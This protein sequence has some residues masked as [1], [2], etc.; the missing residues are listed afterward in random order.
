MIKLAIQNLGKYNE[1]ELNFKWVTLPIDED[2][3][4]EVLEEI[5]INEEYEEYFIADYE[6][7]LGLI[8]GEYSNI[9]ELNELAERLENLYEQ[10][11]KI[12]EAIIELEGDLE[13]ALDIF[14]SGDFTYFTDIY[15]NSD[16]AYAMI[17]EGIIELKD[18]FLS[19]YIDY[20]RL[21]RD[22]AMDY[23]ISGNGIAIN[24]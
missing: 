7:D 18:D 5:G 4:N 13:T 8:I 17:D 1:G 23:H 20:D 10:D 12:L 2:N 19:N 6:T 21:G 11:L 22:L 9:Q 3:F 15:T 24:Y 14:E 16:L